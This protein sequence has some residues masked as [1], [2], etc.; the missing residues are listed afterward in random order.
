MPA[1]A[2]SKL[3]SMSTGQRYAEFAVS[4]FGTDAIVG[5]PETPRA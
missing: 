1:A 2:I 5:D 4:S 3:L